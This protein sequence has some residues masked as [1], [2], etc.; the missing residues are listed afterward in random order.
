[1][2]SSSAI[3]LVGGRNQ[4][5][6]RVE[7]YRS[8]TWQSVCD[9]FWD[10]RE[11]EVVCRQLGYGYAILAIQRAA[12]GQGSGGQW[13]RNWYCTGNEGSLDGCSS[14]S[15]FCSHSE[16]ASVICSNSSKCVFCL[17][18]TVTSFLCTEALSSN[19]YPSSFAALSNGVL[20]LVNTGST[21][22]GGRLEFHFNSSWGT[23][24]SDSWGYTDAV[25]ACRQLGFVGAGI[26]SRFGSGS[27]SQTILLDDVG[28]SGSESRLID[29]N[30]AGI[31][32]ENC[33][34]SED[35]GIVCTNGEIL[36]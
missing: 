36:M 20:R 15:A 34:H 21:Q 22:F 1:M 7:V 5:E 23:V 32:N 6:G 17:L 26:G 31:G 4:Y 18:P 13:D 8:G 25:V 14:S 29:C 33:V 19:L 30:H 35:V 10:I 12:F 2:G 27:S 9:N 16:D 24:C 11:A 28:C 3:R